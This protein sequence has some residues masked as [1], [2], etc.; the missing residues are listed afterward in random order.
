MPPF[1]DPSVHLRE[2]IEVMDREEEHDGE[3]LSDRLA[4]LGVVALRYIV[5]A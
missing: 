3:A 2:K 4:Y 5:H 1:H